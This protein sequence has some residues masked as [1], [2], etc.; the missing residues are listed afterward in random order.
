M[1]RCVFLLACVIK[2]CYLTPFRPRRSKETVYSFAKSIRATT[3]SLIFRRIFKVDSRT[4]TRVTVILLRR[5]ITAFPLFLMKNLMGL[6]RLDSNSNLPSYLI[7]RARMQLPLQFYADIALLCRALC[8][9]RGTS[10]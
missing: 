1:R 6:R 9:T 3:R 7:T 2:G 10:K 5:V 8:A 4:G